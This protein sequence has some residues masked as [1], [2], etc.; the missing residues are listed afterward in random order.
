MPIVVPV[1]YSR[2]SSWPVYSWWCRQLV[3]TSVI[4]CWPI[5]PGQCRVSCPP[6]ARLALLSFDHSSCCST[7][8]LRWLPSVTLQLMVRAFSIICLTMEEGGHILFTWSSYL[9]L[10]RIT[11][12]SNSSIVQSQVEMSS[13][14]S[15]T[16][17][18]RISS[19]I[20]EQS[21][22]GTNKF[23]LRGHVLVRVVQALKAMKRAHDYDSIMI[24]SFHVELW[25]WY[26]ISAEYELHTP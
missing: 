20:L 24:E 5:W 7:L 8:A 26:Y 13:S 6:C 1:W 11:L 3:Q 25:S 9:P 17:L 12:T 15:S 2:M 19:I 18:S 10:P 4:R 14:S 22:G 16:S 23:F 21:E